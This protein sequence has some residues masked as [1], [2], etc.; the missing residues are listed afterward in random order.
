L[1]FNFV[2]LRSLPLYAA[3]E[4]IHQL[5]SDHFLVKTPAPVLPG[6]VNQFIAV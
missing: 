1:G 4:S 2:I 5:T 6:Q 3:G